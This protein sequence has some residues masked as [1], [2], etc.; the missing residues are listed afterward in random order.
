MDSK[1]LE[2]NKTT[3]DKCDGDFAMAIFDIKAGERVSITTGIVNLEMIDL[4]ATGV[5]K[6]NVTYDATAT[7]KYQIFKGVKRRLFIDTSID[8]GCGCYIW[9][10]DGATVYNSIDNQEWAD[11]IE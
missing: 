1:I 5:L 9:L 4:N 7:D 11:T 3:C 6:T 8:F 2:L 10:E